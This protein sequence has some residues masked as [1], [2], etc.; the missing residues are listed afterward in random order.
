MQ[1]L[2]LYKDN[3]K[4]TYKGIVVLSHR[5]LVR[6]PL[7]FIPFKRMPLKS[8]YTTHTHPTPSPPSHTH[9]HTK[10]FNIYPRQF[11]PGPS[12]AKKRD[13]TGKIVIYP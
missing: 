13:I 10:G 5:L 11:Q 8:T 2:S 3:V 1:L 7:T 4:E 6:K 9:T 12:Q